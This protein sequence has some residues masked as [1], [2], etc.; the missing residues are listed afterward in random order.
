MGIK[1]QTLA[2]ITAATTAGGTQVQS[3]S[4]MCEAIVF[5]ADFANTDKV[6]VGDVNISA[7]RFMVSLTAG[8]S[9]M[10]QI[11][12][13]NA[14]GMSNFELNGFY[15]AATTGTQKVHVTYFERLG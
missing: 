8:Q 1:P 6:L 2:A 3:A 12:A 11:N 9:Y 15:C 13:A 10:L 7:T 5:C 4:Q 14:P